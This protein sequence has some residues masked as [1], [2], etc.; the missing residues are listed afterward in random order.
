MMKCFKHQKP[1]NPE[2]GITLLETLLSVGV[3]AVLL[4]MVTQ[5]F[6]TFIR[7]EVSQSVGDYMTLIQSASNETVQTVER[8]NALYARVTA[9]GGV[10]EIPIHAE[11]GVNPDNISLELGGAGVTRSTIVSDTFRDRLP[12]Q[13]RIT[14]VVRE[15]PGTPRALVLMAATLDRIEEDLL[16]GYA[17]AIGP[18]GGYVSA[19][20][21]TDGGLCASEPACQG[22]IRSGFGTWSD[23]VALFAG[24]RWGDTVV[25]TPPTEGDGGYLVSYRFI[26]ETE[27]AGDYL[28]RIPMPAAPELN[29]MNAAL[30]LAGNNLVGVDNI[31][32]NDELV[33]ERELH[34][35]G[36]IYI[37][38]DLRVVGDMQVNGDIR[39]QNTTVAPTYQDTA[40]LSVGVIERGNV[41]VG[42]EFSAG[43]YTVDQD[44]R[45]PEATLDTLNASAIRTITMNSG[46]L[47]V[48]TATPGIFSTTMRAGGLNASDV[49]RAGIVETQTINT[50]NTGA[51]S[52]DGR[53]GAVNF[54]G[55]TIDASVAHVQAARIENLTRCMEG[56]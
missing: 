17:E 35:Q 2:S 36:S 55:P 45:T 31:T 9:N 1:C 52:V 49:V 27:I 51:I 41:M 42:N 12:R 18:G 25:A 23:T 44:L 43:S 4:L 22:L 38:G 8:F 21:P 53:A 11:T 56:C 16:R 34:A 48:N 5:F 47:R 40:A 33:V 3:L 32:V 15:V 46:N 28:F 19:I 13:E 20:V 26:S 29:R 10:L 50:N 54:N 30:D 14:V 37:D 24:T 7:K 39:M 6:E